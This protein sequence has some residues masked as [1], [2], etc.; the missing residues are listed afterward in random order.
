MNRNYKVLM[1]INGV[2]WGGTKEQT[3][4]VTKGLKKEGIDVHIALA[5]QY[6]EMRDKLRPFDVT[7]HVYEYIGKNSRWSISQARR[8]AGIIDREGFD[9]VVANSPKVVGYLSIAKLFMRTKP[10]IISVK[11]S[12]R[13]SGWL[14]KIFKYHIADKIV[15]VSEGVTEQMKR[16]N[17]YPEKLVTIQ[18]GVPTDLFQ[19]NT[20]NRI[21]LRK[22]L[23]IAEDKK[24]FINVANWNPKVKAQDKL[25]EAFAKVKDT[26]ALLV[27]AGGSTDTV[28]MEH[29]R[30]MNVGNRVIGLGYRNDVPALLDMA[31]YYVLSSNLEGVAGSVIQAMI[32]GKV[33]LS[34]LAGGIGSYLKDGENGFTVP[35]GDF[36]GMTAKMEKMLGLS[37]EEE[38]RIIREAK[39]TGETFSIKKTVEKYIQLFDEIYEGES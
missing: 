1:L 18:S 26:D 39:R 5:D 6:D 22:E 23:G 12:G 36:E 30:K 31:D 20:E 34:T 15:V 35:V 9:F 16:D 19:P 29:A 13:K 24:V 21:R 25:I 33:T 38:E 37:P 2:G 4:L 14:S 3:Y 28:A 10:C 32:M 11:R 27:L 7:E 17:F 8:L